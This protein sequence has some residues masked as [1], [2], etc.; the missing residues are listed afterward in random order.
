[1]KTLAPLM[2]IA[3]ACGEK[4]PPEPVAPSWGWV[5]GAHGA[6]WVPETYDNPTPEDLAAGRRETLDQL[7]MQWRGGRND[8]VQFGDALAKEVRDLLRQ[9]PEEVDAVASANLEY[10]LEWSA[11]GVA[12]LGWGGWLQDLPSQLT[13]DD[14]IALLD[15]AWFDLLSVERSWQHELALCPDEQVELS[16]TARSEYELSPKGPL[17]TVSGIVDA[18]V[19]VGAL[20]TD[21]GCLLGVLLGRFESLDG[22]VTIFPIG[23]GLVFT[24]PAEGVLSFA[25]NDSDH[26]DNAYA[27][28]D[29]V[30]DGATVGARPT[31]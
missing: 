9:K 15:E 14:C 11:G 4:T 29:G 28:A 30:Q 23:A 21:E 24:A 8:G 12:T 6:C 2:L 13:V 16:A 18:E 22:Q 26:R 20:C 27:V 31:R 17:S 7:A 19:P 25:V 1:M 3:V 5:E 10:C